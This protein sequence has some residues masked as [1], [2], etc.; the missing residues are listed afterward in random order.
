M[1]PLLALLAQSGLGAGAIVGIVVGVV[2]ASGSIAAVLVGLGRVLS[3]LDSLREESRKRGDEHA[4][5]LKALRA[6]LVETT[7]ALSVG[8][9]RA[10]AMER[11][12]EVLE[13][14]VEK[15]RASSHDQARA[16]QGLAARAG[17]S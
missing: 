1:S 4:A 17:A 13:R 3:S 14:E 2:G 15:L 11:R 12:V 8:E 7:R 10:E 9:T 6:D 5:E 16:L